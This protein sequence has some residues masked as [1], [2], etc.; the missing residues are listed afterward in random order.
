MPNLIPLKNISI[1]SSLMEFLFLDTVCKLT[2][3]NLMK[4]LLQ[5]EGNIQEAGTY[6]Q[7]E[8]EFGCP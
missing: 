3:G 2:F 5:D 4:T 7:V 1:D 8:L 6:L